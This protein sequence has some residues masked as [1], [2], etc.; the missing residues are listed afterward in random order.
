[1]SLAAASLS[2]TS[3]GWTILP[4][5]EGASFFQSASHPGLALCRSDSMPA[6]DNPILKRVVLGHSGSTHLPDHSEKEHPTQITELWQILYR[7]ID[8]LGG[9]PFFI[10]SSESWIHR[11]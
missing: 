2:E 9:V 1:V 10:L 11:D 5:T 8:W 7:Y 6:A 3:S 4:L